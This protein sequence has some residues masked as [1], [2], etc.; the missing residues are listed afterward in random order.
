MGG[1]RHAPSSDMTTT[2]PS[3]ARRRASRRSSSLVEPEM[4]EYVALPVE[5]APAVLD[6]W[7]AIVGPGLALQK[8]HRA[9]A[10]F[11]DR[12]AGKQRERVRLPKLPLDISNFQSPVSHFRSF[13]VSAAE[14]GRP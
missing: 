5:A 3:G 7:N 6:D 13:P 12:F 11:C 8:G 10:D 14:I 4:A 9:L 2:R 1:A